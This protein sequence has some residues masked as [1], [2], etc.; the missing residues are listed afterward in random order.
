MIPKPLCVYQHV[1]LILQLR[2]WRL[3][4][5]AKTVLEENSLLVGGV[6]TALNNIYIGS[7]AQS[8]N[9]LIS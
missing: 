6:D 4:S 1:T 5:S 7:Q 3:N 8:P 9:F 2:A